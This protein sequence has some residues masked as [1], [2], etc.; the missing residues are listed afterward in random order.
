MKRATRSI[1]LLLAALAWAWGAAGHAQETLPGGNVD[2]LLAYARE[3]NPEYATMRHEADAA[4][5]R[6]QSAGALAD[7][8]LRVE[9]ENV[10]NYGS[11]ARPSL[12]PNRV[13][14]TKY[15]VMQP[16][17]FWGKRALKREVAEAD[18]D[19]AQGKATATWA[20]LSARIKSAY[21]ELYY[22]YRNQRLTREILDLMARLEQV[23]QVRYAGGLTAQQ[24][25]IRAQVEQTAMKSELIALETEH[26]HMRTR[27]N[28]LLARPADASLAEPERLRPIPAPANLDLAALED[29]V[30]ARNPQLFTQDARV[31]SA[32]KSR[33]LT[34]RNRYPDLLFGVVPMQTGNRVNTWGLMLE[35]N[36]PLQQGSR[37]SQEREAESML[38]AARS[39]KEAAA[40][41]VLSDLAENLAGI[42]AARRTEMLVATNL[43]PQADLTFRAALTGYENG[44]VDFATLLDSQRQIR[45]AKQDRLKAQTEAQ[46]RLAEI[47]RLLGEDL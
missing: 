20:E 31:R 34:Y 10:T 2:S 42:D 43:L 24:D 21:A 6:I 11:D 14:D 45:K 39:R 23:A 29:R 13:G 33:E 36:I 1:G 18:A 7:P 27:I 15:T 22:V 32:E 47:E 38:S 37:R 8:V 16:L 12:L 41:Q 28:M 40:N 4:T 44:K 19:Q 25:V 5:E 46:I 17:P 35:M 9:L 26:H 3:H 30:H